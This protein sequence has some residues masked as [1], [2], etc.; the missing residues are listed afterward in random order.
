MVQAFVFTKQ[1]E[2]TPI[3][4]LKK[5]RDVRYEC[6]EIQQ[7]FFFFLTFKD[8]LHSAVK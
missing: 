5:K 1:A 2:L 3:D 6:Y 4:Q 7:F 8:A